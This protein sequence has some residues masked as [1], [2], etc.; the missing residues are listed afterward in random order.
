MDDHTV[1][2]HAPLSLATALAT[3]APARAIPH[4]ARVVLPGTNGGS[5]AAPLPSEFNAA[6]QR[7]CLHIASRHGVK[8]LPLG[9][10][11][12]LRAEDKYI[13]VY[14]KTNVYLLDSSLR[15]LEKEIAPLFFRAHRN[16]LVALAFVSGVEWLVG[17]T[18]P[19]E[20]CLPHCGKVQRIPVARREQGTVVAILR[21][22]G[23]T[24]KART[25]P[26]VTTAASAPS[27]GPG[28]LV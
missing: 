9:V 19:V 20:V 17:C 15:R 8:I 27:S 3:Q 10:I 22:R 6:G 2:R 23:I 16:C 14:T 25:A 21:K 12:C 5:V 4:L 26:V 24:L 13:E 18:G 7:V 1:T 28:A 11:T